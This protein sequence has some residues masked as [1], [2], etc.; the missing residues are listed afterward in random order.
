MN[1]RNKKFIIHSLRVRSRLMENFC[2][3]N[4]GYLLKTFELKFFL[5]QKV[6]LIIFKTINILIIL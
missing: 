4:S 6:R 5:L 3:F 1:C 2:M